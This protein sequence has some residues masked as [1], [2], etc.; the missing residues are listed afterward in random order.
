MWDSSNGDDMSDDFLSDLTKR[1]PEPIPESERIY[2]GFPKRAK[3]S[4]DIDAREERYQ[5]GGE[6]GYGPSWPVPFYEPGELYPDPLTKDEV[7]NLR[8]VYGITE[9][10]YRE[11]MKRDKP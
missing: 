4:A 8:D 11:L 6:L 7:A 1:D 3:S 10:E 9:S 2:V 5:R